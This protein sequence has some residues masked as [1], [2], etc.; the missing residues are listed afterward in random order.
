MKGLGRVPNDGEDGDELQFGQHCF[1]FPKVSLDSFEF[2]HNSFN[3]VPQ[4]TF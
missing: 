1:A 3:N 2:L 4:L